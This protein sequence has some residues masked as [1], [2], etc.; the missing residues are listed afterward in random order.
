MNVPLIVRKVL[1]VS[2]LTQ[3]ALAGKIGVSQ[4]TISKW[5]NE[6]QAPNMDQWNRFVAF[7]G[8]YP[9]LRPLLKSGVGSSSVPIEGYIGAGAE[10]LPEFEQIP[11]EGLEDVELPFDVSSELIAFRVRGDSMHPA[12][13]DGDVVMVWREQRGAPESYYGNEV[14]VRTLAGQRFIKEIHPG[15]KKGVFTLTSHNAKPISDVRLAWVG[16]IQGMVKA[17]QVQT[18]PRQRKM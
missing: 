11:P 7:A 6:G 15:Q 14:A 5:M 1:D 2:G 10:V 3:A 16:E 13:R 17:N 18:I 4:G 12:Y 9:T 8:R